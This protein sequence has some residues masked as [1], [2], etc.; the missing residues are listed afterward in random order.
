VSAVQVL[1][2]AGWQAALVTGET[3]LAAAWQQLHRLPVS[4]STVSASTVSASTV[5]GTPSGTGAGR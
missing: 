4:A 3:T 1:V 2:A 5:P